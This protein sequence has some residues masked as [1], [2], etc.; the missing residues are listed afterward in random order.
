LNLGAE[1]AE[2]ETPRGEGNGE[3]GC[4]LPSRLGGLGKRRKL[5]QWGPGQSPD[6]KR[7]FEY[8]ELENTHLIATNLSYLT[9]LRH[10]LVTFT[11]TVTKHKTFT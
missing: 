1:G 8:L 7:V 2:I 3:Q 9:F 4:P 11:L 5:P 6:R 10:I